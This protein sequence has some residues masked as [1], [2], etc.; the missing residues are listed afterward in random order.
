MTKDQ[1][2]PREM[3]LA[4]VLAA[5]ERAHAQMKQWPEWK[6]KISYLESSDT[7]KAS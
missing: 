1:S 3:S 4:Q 6:R 7:P 2:Q 5:A